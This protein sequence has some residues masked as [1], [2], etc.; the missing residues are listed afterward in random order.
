LSANASPRAQHPLPR[1]APGCPHP[2][3][4]FY[5]R[6][7]DAV[8]VCVDE[9]PMQALGRKYPT[10]TSPDGTVRPPYEASPP[11]LMNATP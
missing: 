10:H 6:I 4:G 5:E 1:P 8:V 7:K 11:S 2:Q 3:G 9:K